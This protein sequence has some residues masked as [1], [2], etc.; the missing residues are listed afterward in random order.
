VKGVEPP[1][2]HAP[3]HGGPA[4]AHAGK[5]RDGHDAVLASRDPS[6]I[7]VPGRGWLAFVRSS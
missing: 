5:L 3:R 2:G 1:G 6:Q 7:G 4:Q